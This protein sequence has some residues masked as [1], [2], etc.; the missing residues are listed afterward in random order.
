MEQN[1][2][3]GFA[4]KFQEEKTKPY[5]R[6]GQS[7]GWGLDRVASRNCILK[8]CPGTPH[9][10]IRDGTYGQPSFLGMKTETTISKNPEYDPESL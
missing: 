9:F 10:L 5:G 2:I 8:R 4:L 3:L 1:R 7:P 6:T